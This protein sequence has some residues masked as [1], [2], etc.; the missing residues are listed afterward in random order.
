[1]KKPEFGW[2]SKCGASWKTIYGICE[3]NEPCCVCWYCKVSSKYRVMKKPD[4]KFK[5]MKEINFNHDYYINNLPRPSE[6]RHST[7]RWP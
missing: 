7:G 5:N 6:I 1:M 2:C 4:T 3:S